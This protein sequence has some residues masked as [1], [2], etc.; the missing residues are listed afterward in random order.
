MLKNE[1]NMWIEVDV[2]VSPKKEKKYHLFDIGYH[3][4][5][6]VTEISYQNTYIKSYHKLLWILHFLQPKYA[7]KKIMERIDFILL[8]TLLQEKI[9]FHSHAEKKLD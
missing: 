9:L 8:L 3:H 6:S 1:P 2:S 7:Y 4:A 5:H